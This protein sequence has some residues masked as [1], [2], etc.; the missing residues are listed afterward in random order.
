MLLDKGMRSPL[1]V[2]F[3]VCSVG[4]IHNVYAAEAQDNAASADAKET[5]V[6]ENDLFTPYIEPLYRPIPKQVA[7]VKM[8]ELLLDGI[9]HTRIETEL[10]KLPTVPTRLEGDEWRAVSYTHLTLPTN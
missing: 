6:A 5:L 7:G 1:T 8:P 9:W 3:A 10:A 4:L 2:V